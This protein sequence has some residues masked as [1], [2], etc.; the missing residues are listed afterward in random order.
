MCCELIDLD[1]EHKYNS[2][3]LNVI[4]NKDII[5]KENDATSYEVYAIYMN[6]RWR[7]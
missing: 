7:G 1:R 5:I 3:R 4:A 2:D 6:G